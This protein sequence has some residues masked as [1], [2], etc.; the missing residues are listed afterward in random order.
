MKGKLI[1]F[2]GIEGCG[3]TTQVDRTCRWMESQGRPFLRTREPGGTGIGRQIRKILLD[4]RNRTL[5]AMAELMLYAADRAQHIRELIRPAL[6]RG[7]WV[8]CDRFVDATLAYQGDGRGLDRKTIA[9]L[10]EMATGGLKPALTLLID[11]PVE[12]G[13]SR[14]IRRNHQE[15]ATREEGR[16][17]AEEVAF[18]ERVRGSYLRMAEAEPDRFRL[19]D[20]TQSPDEIHRGIVSFLSPCL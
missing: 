3:K 12:I 11:L 7:E 8:L 13:L 16:F 17:E 1:T 19:L 2:E 18:H 4:T 5:D 10:N 14:A 9:T 20:G 15:G 6:D